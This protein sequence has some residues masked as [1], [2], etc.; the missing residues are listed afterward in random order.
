MWVNTGFSPVYEA[1]R[2]W[3]KLCSRAK[4]LLPDFPLCVTEEHDGLEDICDKLAVLARSPLPP[5]APPPPPTS[6]PS[7]TSTGEKTTPLD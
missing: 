7:P 2:H 6:T 5:S 4:T 1:L 3:F